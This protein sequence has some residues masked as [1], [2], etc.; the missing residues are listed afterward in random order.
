MDNIRETSNAGGFLRFAAAAF[1]AS[2][3]VLVG[4][5]AAVDPAGVLAGTPREQAMAEQVTAGR[6]LAG[7]HNFDER[8]FQVSRI[9]LMT[10]RSD[11]VVLGSSRAMQIRDGFLPG[12]T[13]NL[14]VSGAGLEDY[15][16]LLEALVRRDMLPR[17]VLIVADPW[18][19][20]ANNQQNRWRSLGRDCAAFAARL[21]VWGI[22][23]EYLWSSTGRNW[24][25]L[26]S[27]GYLRES[28]ARLAADG[29]GALHAAAGSGVVAGTVDLPLGPGGRLA[30]GSTLYPAAERA[31]PAAALDVS[32]VTFA[33][34]KPVYSLEG[35]TAL[36]P[37]YTDAF[38]TMIGYLL[39]AGVAVTIVLPPYHP[40]T[41]G[42]LQ[43]DPAYGPMITATE[44]FLRAVGARHGAPVLGGYLDGACNGDEFYDPNH[45]R[46][47]CMASVVGGRVPLEYRGLDVR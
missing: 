25:E 18:L 8:L 20:N 6:H 2:M 36:S 39:S 41:A 10:A 45:P 34:V 28:L 29:L 35:F 26:V 7:M 33:K 9:G 3:V 17:E 12:R 15:L 21:K 37:L 38:D 19:F 11:R 27:L 22:C 16:A 13:V 31:E 46:Q 43:A 24:R 30:D 44:A 47:S 4:I 42:L 32:A 5:N 23:P 40:V 14:S 1:V